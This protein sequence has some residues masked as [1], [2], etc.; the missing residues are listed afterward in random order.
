MVNLALPPRAILEVHGSRIR[1]SDGRWPVQQG[2]R[3]PH[4][5]TNPSLTSLLLLPQW[6]VSGH[7]LSNSAALLSSLPCLPV[8]S[9]SLRGSRLSKPAPPLAAPAT[10]Q[11]SLCGRWYST[12]T[13]F[14]GSLVTPTF[15]SFRGR[16]AATITTAFRI[17][18]QTHLWIPPA[19][20]SHA[21]VV[22]ALTVLRRTT[23]IVHLE[24]N[25]QLNEYR[26]APRPQHPK[27]F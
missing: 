27:A 8:L 6:S 24:T 18:S 4:S 15:S 11:S 7:R 23:V 16:L 26:S 22:P 14:V 17:Q 19:T 20:D 3:T 10:T 21:R 2:V 5:R 12:A 25:F 13:S 9:T 1:R